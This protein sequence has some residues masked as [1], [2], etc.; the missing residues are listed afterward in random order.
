MKILVPTDYSEL[1][2][3]A[4]ELA[5]R[6]VQ[7]SADLNLLNLVQAPAGALMDAQGQVLEDG[8][9]DLSAYRREWS[10]SQAQMAEWTATYACAGEVRTAKLTTGILHHSQRVGAE[11]IVMGTE[12]SS[13][14]KE[15]LS[16]SEAGELALQSP[17]PVLTLK[18]D[19]KDMQFKNAMIIGDFDRVQKRPLAAVREL[20]RQN[21]GQWHLLA[22]HAQDQDQCG[23]RQERM[24]QFALLN[25]LGECKLHFHR[26]GSQEL[27]LIQ[28]LQELELDVL[29]IAVRQQN[30]AT[31]LRGDLALALVHHFHKPIYLYPAKD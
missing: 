17:V 8:E 7:D 29:C 1:S 5:Q 14:L 13:G 26:Q 23:A 2:K 22:L 4:V 20:V 18:C 9:M 19:R 10:Q 30:L 12:G 3:W 31:W 21:N 24:H 25:E 16:R 11:L 27:A 28:L 15:L 6:L